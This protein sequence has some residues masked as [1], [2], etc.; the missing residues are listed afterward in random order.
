MFK[1]LAFSI[2]VFIGLVP[3]SESLA[4]TEAQS[5]R[6]TAAYN[7]A[8]LATLAIQT[9]QSTNERFQTAVN[10]GFRVTFDV[11]AAATKNGGGPGFFAKLRYLTGD[12]QPVY[13]RTFNAA[14]ARSTRT[15][16][17]HKVDS[18]LGLGL[19]G[20][21]LV[22]YI[23]DG[24]TARTTHQ[25]FGGRLS[26][27]D[28]NTGYLGLPSDHAT[29]V[30][31]T[32]IAK[33]VNPKAKGMAP[34]AFGKTFD[35]DFDRAE[36]IVEAASGMLVSNHSYG[37]M[38][39]HPTTGAVL[40]PN[41]YFGGYLDE[42]RSWDEVMFS[43]PYYLMV[44]AAGNDGEDDTA[45]SNP[46]GGNAAYDKL[47]GHCT[48]KNNLVVANVMDVALNTGGSIAGPV[49]KT[50]SS[51]EGPTDDLRIK[52]DISGNG[53]ELLSTVHLGSAGSSNDKYQQ[54]NWTGTSMAAPNVSGSLLLLQELYEREN[55][56]FMRA[57][58]LKGLAI[59]TADDIGPDGPDAE[60]GWGL[61]NASFAAQTILGEKNGSAIVV[62]KQLANGSEF[63]QTFKAKGNVKV[64][65]C[66][67]DP[68]GQATPESTVNNASPVLVNDLNLRLKR[69]S[70]V[71]MPWLLTAV[72]SN[73]KGNN[74]VDPVERIEDP[75][76][77]ASLSEY[78]ITVS[79]ADQLA[80]GSQAFSLIVTGDSLTAQGDGPLSDG[81]DSDST[82][83]IR[84][85]IDRV[86]KE[87]ES[88]RE[89]LP[90]KDSEDLG[91]NTGP[92]PHRRFC[93]KS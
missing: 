45:N 21:D 75:G 6:A 28:A 15:D 77:R 91:A 12:G 79:H 57:A 53:F 16:L 92:A 30:A 73:T 64:T 10:A 71:F 52:P 35:W 38:F 11:D 4:Q 34:K 88:I 42:A 62:E 25:E 13:Y 56:E 19:S 31:G 89:Q 80:N 32:M 23:W 1:H 51:S 83:E 41:S 60:F 44:V 84:R 61:L 69:D 78:E 8:A 82:E 86:I 54:V 26:I 90:T 2:V 66:W 43:A 70:T 5:Q 59:H 87:L 36:A 3:V 18:G 14:A 29:H 20:K 47:T 76:S 93:F 74:R 9:R 67:T 49:L 65:I 37:F 58:T 46:L 40:L 81:L 27:G 39:R 85:R 72:D 48:A 55:G 50:S 22:A 24:G 63:K 7:K 33:G 17:L 68:A